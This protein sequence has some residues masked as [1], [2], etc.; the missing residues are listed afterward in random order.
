MVVNFSKFI[1][2]YRFK[3]KSWTC[4]KIKTNQKRFSRFSKENINFILQKSSLLNFM[5]Q[6]QGDKN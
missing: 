2:K 3:T 4:F 6:Q 5:V 1:T